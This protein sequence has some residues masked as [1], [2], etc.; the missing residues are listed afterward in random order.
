M[1]SLIAIPFKWE[2][3]HSNDSDSWRTKVF[4]GWI[5]KTYE[6]CHITLHEDMRPQTGYEW[7]VATCFVPDP[8][9]EWEIA[10]PQ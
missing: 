9:Y 6:E 5:V 10:P 4:G 7:R 2:R 3:I 8:N 1:S